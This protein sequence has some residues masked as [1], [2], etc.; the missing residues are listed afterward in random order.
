LFD[1]GI[2]YIHIEVPAELEGK[3]IAAYIAKYF[4]D[5]AEEHHLKIKLYLPYIKAY[6][7]K[8]HGY[9]TNSL[10]HNKQ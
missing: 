5:Y 8:H 7:D 3:G 1:G 2:A 4:L 10:F 9:Q 6:S